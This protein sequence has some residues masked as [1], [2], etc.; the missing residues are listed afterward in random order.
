MSFQHSV[1][2]VNSTSQE[3]ALVRAFSLQ[4]YSIPSYRTP[5]IVADG[6]AGPRT[7]EGQGSQPRGQHHH[8]A[9]GRRRLEDDRHLHGQPR[10][11]GEAQVSHDLAQPARHLGRGQQTQRGAV[12]VAVPQ[13]GRGL[14]AVLDVP[15]APLR[16]AEPAAD[17]G[18]GAGEEQ[19]EQRRLEQA[20]DPGPTVSKH[21]RFR[22]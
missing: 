17:A 7:A 3:K 6:E 19:E 11:Q 1:L 18:G 13:Q 10:A 2:N 4:H 22:G 12:P 21:L 5:D 20:P 8:E 14:L 9:R 15:A 16:A